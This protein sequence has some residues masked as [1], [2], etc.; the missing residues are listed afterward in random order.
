MHKLTNNSTRRTGRAKGFRSRRG[1]ALFVTLFFVGAIGALAMSA[2]YLTENASLLSKSYEREDDLKY[3]SEAALAIGKAELNFNPSAL[4]NTS[5]VALMTN[6]PVVAADGQVVPGV[7]VDVYLG[8]TGSTTGQFGR[9]A[10]LVAKA[11]TAD[12]TGFARRLEL[13]QESFAKYAYWT[14]SEGVNISFGN[15]DQLFGPVWS[16]D[17]LH[18]MSSGATFRDS[19][20]TAGTIVGVGYGTFAKGY[21]TGLKKISLPTLTT[22]GT[23]SGLATVGGMNFTAPT[24]GNATTVKKRIEFVAVD[25]DLNGDSLGD[26]E[27]FFRVYGVTANANVAW[28]RGDWPANGLAKP[29]RIQTCGDWHAVDAAGTKKFFPFSVHY[30]SLNPGTNTWFDTVTAPA[31]LPGG[32][33]I[34]QARAEADSLVSGT[35]S[36][37]QAV[38]QHPGA[39]CYLG[40]DPHL[41]AVAR[42]GVAG[43]TVATQVHIGGDETTFTPTDRYGTWTKYSDLPPGIVTTR[44]PNDSKYLFPLWRGYNTSTKGVIYVAGTVGVS[45]VLRGD[46]TMYSPNTI[47]ILDDLRYAKDPA[48]P[49]PPGIPECRD[50][51]GIIA[52]DSTVV[53]D[54]G[55]NTPQ[56]VRSGGSVY[57]S[58]DDTPDTYIHSVIMALNSFGVQNYDQNPTNATPCQ[59]N[60]SGRGCLFLTGGLIQNTRG[61]VGTSTSGSPPNVT[62]FVKRYS[63]DRCAVMNPPPY[64]PT[65]GRFQDNRYYEL[66]PVRLD[67]TQLFNSLSPNG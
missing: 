33:T 48:A 13:S 65:T 64:F 6:Q 43:Y 26:A 60:N 20:G 30:D 3:A 53:A 28:L 19:V 25:L 31:G 62:G 54:N 10:S 8:Q 61:A 15:G 57:Q 36:K 63:Y 34:A 23:L 51:L 18:I 4:P 40:G 46:I 22:L 56:N 39:R 5:Y 41:A 45:G 1:I 35:A 55:L 27:G 32:R 7:S 17:D 21:Q 44:R 9:F 42:Q 58:F 14:N 38:L 67:I 47:V 11:H 2:I 37:I 66:D 49:A 24:T 12:G 50:I 29:A 52:G 16:N 59:A